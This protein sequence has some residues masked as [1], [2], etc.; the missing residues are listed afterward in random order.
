M[1]SLRSISMQLTLSPRKL[2]T[3]SGCPVGVSTVSVGSLRGFAY[4]PAMRPTNS[5]G[6]P[7][8]RSSISLNP[9]IA[10]IF[11]SIITAVHSA[12]DSAQSPHCNSNCC[13][14]AHLHSSSLRRRTSADS[15]I[16]GKS[17]IWVKRTLCRVRLSNWWS[18]YSGCWMIGKPCQEVGVQVDVVDIFMRCEMVVREI[19]LAGLTTQTLA[20][21]PYSD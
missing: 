2:M 8:A 19:I 21:T 13:P 10:F 20:G 11:F 6:F 12:N 5:T 7:E 16:S 14:A 4:C 18:R 15:T 3:F 1:G 17:D 9:Y